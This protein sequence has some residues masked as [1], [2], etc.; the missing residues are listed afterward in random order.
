MRHLIHSPLH[1]YHS[2]QDIYTPHCHDTR[3]SIIGHIFF[4]ELSCLEI[5]SGEVEIESMGIVLI[6]RTIDRGICIFPDELVDHHSLCF[7]FYCDFIERPSIVLIIHL[8]I[9]W[10]G[11][12]DMCPIFFRG[13]FETRGKIDRISEDGIVPPIIRSDIP[14]HHFPRRYPDAEVDGCEST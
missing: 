9:G 10:S 12:D 11:D 8:F 1:D 6:L 4:E 7:P 14:D 2:L 13:G 5:L 3:R